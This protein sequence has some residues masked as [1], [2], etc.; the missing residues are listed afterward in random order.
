MDLAVCWDLFT[1]CIE[2]SRVLSEDA[3]FRE[4][5][6]SARGKLFPYQVGRYGQ[7]QEWFQDFAEAEPGHR[8]MSHLYAVHPG[9]QIT[10]RGTPD[11]AKA[12]RTSLE[13]RLSAGGGH[14]GWSRAWLISQWAR[15][16]DAGRAYESVRLLLAKSTL[17]N[18]F[19]THPPFQIDGNFGGTAGIAEM[20]LQ[21]HA[22]DIHILPALPLQWANGEV[23]G[24]RARGALEVGILW[25]NGKA[26][27][28][29]L[30]A[31]SDSTHRVRPPLGQSIPGMKPLDDGSFEINL[32]RGREQVLRFV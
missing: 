4:K 26:V 28:A 30:R 15:Q 19:D 17:P 8:H 1:N 27:T 12:A 23:R 5:L 21:S 14:T 24:L 32:Q 9:R 29:S 22:G 10:P 16:H 3:A 7:L 11:L 31:L 13:R 25:R 2:A 18:L 20:L 6:E